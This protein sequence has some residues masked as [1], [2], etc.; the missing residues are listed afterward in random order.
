[1]GLETTAIYVAHSQCSPACQRLLGN[2]LLR[3]TENLQNRDKLSIEVEN[4]C[5]ESQV[6]AEMQA[7]DWTRHRVI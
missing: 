3:L 1:M 5:E 4:V 7:F 6:R 2:K